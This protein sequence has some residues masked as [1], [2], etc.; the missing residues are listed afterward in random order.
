MD[1]TLDYL[2]SHSMYVKGTKEHLA[3]SESVNGTNLGATIG[4]IWLDVEGT[5]VGYWCCRPIE[6]FILILYITV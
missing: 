4:M 2:A 5:Q 3:A 1:D 6:Y